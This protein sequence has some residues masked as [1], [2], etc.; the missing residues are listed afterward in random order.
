ARLGAHRLAALEQLGR[1]VGGVEAVGVGFDA[2]GAPALE[3]LASLAHQLGQ[4]HERLSCGWKPGSGGTPRAPTPRERTRVRV[5]NT[6]NAPRGCQTPGERW[7]TAAAARPSRT[8]RLR[9]GP[10]RSA[11]PPGGG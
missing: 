5:G 6:R 10:S 8:G 2:E 3:L 9:P 1:V 4:R 7:L 11:T